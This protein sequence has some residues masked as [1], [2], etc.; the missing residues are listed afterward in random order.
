LTASTRKEELLAGVRANVSWAIREAEGLREDLRA[1][2]EADR[3]IY[4]GR[5]LG[6]ILLR[7]GPREVAALGKRSITIDDLG[8]A[9]MS[10][11]RDAC[12]LLQ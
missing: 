6:G 7:C 8:D 1:A 12:G 11:V 4:A 5:V 10:G 2:S 3:I 9:V